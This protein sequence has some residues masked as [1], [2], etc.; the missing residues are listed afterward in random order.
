MSAKVPL[1]HLFVLVCTREHTKTGNLHFRNG[2]FSLHF[3]IQSMFHLD[4]R[5]KSSC[6]FKTVAFY[7]NRNIVLLPGLFQDLTVVVNC[8]SSSCVF[9]FFA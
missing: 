6:V 9:C 7:L 3:G 5:Q 8:S 2:S 1:K 4:Q